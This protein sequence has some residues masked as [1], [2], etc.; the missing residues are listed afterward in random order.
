MEMWGERRVGVRCI[1]WLDRRFGRTVVTCICETAAE[2]ECLLV[3]VANRVR[4][5]SRHFL[6]FRCD[7]GNCAPQPSPAKLPRARTIDEPL[8]TCPR[9]GP[10]RMIA[11]KRE[12]VRAVH[13][14]K[15]PGAD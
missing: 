12:S 6:T 15:R 3:E 8:P 1:G 13:G 7:I 5:V 4:E 9:R 10:E 14:C 2:G 11:L